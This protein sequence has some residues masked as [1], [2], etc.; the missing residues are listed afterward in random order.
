MNI[1]KF[2]SAINRPIHLCV[3]PKTSI[4]SLH[5]LHYFI[6]TLF[7]LFSISSTSTQRLSDSMRT[8]QHPHVLKSDRFHLLSYHIR[9]SSREGLPR[10]SNISGWLAAIQTNRVDCAINTYEKFNWYRP[11]LLDG[12][13]GQ[14]STRLLFKHL[15]TFLSERSALTTGDQLS[16]F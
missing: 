14:I 13:S 12:A 10:S 8:H 5:S 4:D 7:S 1:D 6:S 2:I 16:D 11:T 9:Q 15:R 3:S